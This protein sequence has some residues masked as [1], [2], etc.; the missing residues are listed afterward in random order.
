MRFNGR[1]VIKPLGGLHDVPRPLGHDG[2]DLFVDD[3]DRLRLLRARRVP[4]AVRCLGRCVAQ[5]LQAIAL[6]D[7]LEDL[8]VIG[9]SS[10]RQDI[11]S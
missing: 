10:P 5:E 8:S 7:N 11:L 3:L 9:D 4:S 2:L 1:N 6:F